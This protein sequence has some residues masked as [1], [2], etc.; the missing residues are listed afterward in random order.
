[1][2][3]EPKFLPVVGSKLPYSSNLYTRELSLQVDATP[4]EVTLR[5]IDDRISMAVDIEPALARLIAAELIAAADAVT[6]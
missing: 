6:Q 4:R 2:T 5:V 3:D 1:M